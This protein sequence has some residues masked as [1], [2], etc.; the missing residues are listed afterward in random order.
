MNEVLIMTEQNA[1]T[2]KLAVVGFIISLVS[3]ALLITTLVLN[4]LMWDSVSSDSIHQLAALSAFILPVIGLVFAIIG[5]IISVKR[6][7]K[8]KGFAVTALIISGLE[9]VFSYG[10]IILL[11]MSALT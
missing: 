1:R 8:G 9:V 7:Q 11:I 2:N 3:L 10:G 6:K 5:L 4:G